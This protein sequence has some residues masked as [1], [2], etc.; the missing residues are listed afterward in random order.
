MSRTDV[1]AY[2]RSWNSAVAASA[3]VARVATLPPFTSASLNP[4]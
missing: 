3:I 4:A 1:P 2:P